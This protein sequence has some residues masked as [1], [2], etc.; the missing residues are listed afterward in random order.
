[1]SNLSQDLRAVVKL[2]QVITPLASTTQ[3]V[4]VGANT[5]SLNGPAASSLQAPP[6]CVMT[7]K[8]GQGGE[9]DIIHVQRQ[10]GVLETSLGGGIPELPVGTM[11]PYGGGADVGGDGICG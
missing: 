4:N 3:T 6:P 7:V 9:E 2:L 8:I 5:A 11:G 1:M 10:D